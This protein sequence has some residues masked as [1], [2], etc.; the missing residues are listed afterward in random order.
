MEG[1]ESSYCRHCEAKPEPCIPNDPI[2]KA[3]DACVKCG[4]LKIQVIVVDK[5][6]EPFSGHVSLGANPHA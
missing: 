4:A 1:Y 6:P 5:L 3:D 2:T